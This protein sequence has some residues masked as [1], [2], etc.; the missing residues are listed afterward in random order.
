MKRKGKL[1]L[2]LSATVIMLAGC[3]GDK[4]F[5]DAQLDV[6]SIAVTS[7]SI[8]EEGKLLTVTAAAERNKPA[9]ENQSPAVSW[10]AVEGA[11][12]Y[13]VVMFDEDANWLHF[14]VDGIQDTKLEQGAYTDKEVYVGPYPPKIAGTHNY[15]IEVFAVK[16]IPNGGIGR[17]NAKN[18]YRGLVNHLNQVGGNSD[19]IIARGYITGSY[20]RGD[21]TVL[22]E[23]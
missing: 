5:T 20:T 13:T 2:I 1:G 23:E 6:P 3:G 19:N 15:R 7:S 12:Y 8:N 17:M 10:E 4:T 14:W 9:G 22:E 11:S 21:D 18:S 16:E